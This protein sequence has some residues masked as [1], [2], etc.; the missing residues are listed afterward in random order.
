MLFGSGCPSV[1]EKSSGRSPANLEA[2]SAN[3]EAQKVEMPE[4]AKQL[5]GDFSICS[6]ATLAGFWEEHLKEEEAE[7]GSAVEDGVAAASSEDKV[8]REDFMSLDVSEQELQ[9]LECQAAE[10]FAKE[11][12]AEVMGQASINH[13]HPCRGS[14]LVLNS[15]KIFISSIPE[16]LLQG[17]E[18]GSVWKIFVGAVKH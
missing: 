5:E 10:E 17:W 11:A 1:L 8:Y 13:G 9:V 3:V 15:P 18:K 14:H 12:A 16:R 4:L 7:R 2:E 6:D